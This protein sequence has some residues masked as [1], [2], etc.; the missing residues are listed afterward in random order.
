MKKSTYAVLA[1]SAFFILA[2]FLFMPVMFSAKPYQ[3]HYS[4]HPGE[5][6]PYTLE[7]NLPQETYLLENFSTLMV[8]DKSP[9]NLYQ[10]LT[11]KIM[12]S[13]SVTVPELRINKAWMDNITVTRAKDNLSIVFDAH[14]LA[15]EDSPLRRNNSLEVPQL[16]ETIATVVIPRHNGE[17]NF[18]MPQFRAELCNF[19]DSR[20]I[21]CSQKVTLQNCDFASF[22]TYNRD[23]YDYPQAWLGQPEKLTLK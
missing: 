5:S 18:D 17:L 10:P 15:P 3:I 22:A 4:E 9:L 2:S 19:K 1:L 7:A 8:Y 16:L 6:N 11:V 21:L 14:T 13:D 20:V 12:E 23:P